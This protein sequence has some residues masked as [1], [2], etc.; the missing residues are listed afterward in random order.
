M[1]RKKKPEGTRFSKT[2]AR[3]SEDSGAISRSGMKYS[4]IQPSVLCTVFQILPRTAYNKFLS[5][6]W[7]TEALN[8]RN[9]DLSYRTQAALATTG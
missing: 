1:R 6:V 2:A 4:V 7:L 3:Q 8:Y 9:E 5:G